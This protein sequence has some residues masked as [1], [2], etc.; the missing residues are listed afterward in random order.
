MNGLEPRHFKIVAGDREC[1][2]RH[3]QEGLVVCYLT[4]TEYTTDPLFVEVCFH[5]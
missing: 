2:T 5:L 1:E 3:V 4:S